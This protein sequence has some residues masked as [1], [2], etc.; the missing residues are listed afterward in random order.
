M[1]TEIGIP[2]AVLPNVRGPK[3]L[4]A[5]KIQ[6]YDLKICACPSII[7]KTVYGNYESQQRTIVSKLSNALLAIA[8]GVAG[9]GR[10]VGASSFRLEVEFFLRG[11]VGVVRGPSGIVVGSRKPL[12]VFHSPSRLTLRAVKTPTGVRDE[13]RWCRVCRSSWIPRRRRLD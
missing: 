9:D 13:G 1:A 11:V 4:P 3:A 5:R 8:N 2:T 7:L 6:L 12:V 10:R